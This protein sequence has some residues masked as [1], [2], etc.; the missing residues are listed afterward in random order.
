MKS[1]LSLLAFVFFLFSVALQGQTNFISNGNKTAFSK[2][3]Q[4]SVF[5]KTQVFEPVKSISADSENVLKSFSKDLNAELSNQKWIA[6]LKENKI[7]ESRMKAQ[8][9]ITFIKNTNQDKV[10]LFGNPLMGFT[11][12]KLV[13]DEP[14][15]F[16]NTLLVYS[17]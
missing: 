4:F 5:Q 7:G 12:K 17:F 13:F 14:A 6:I 16:S 1:I 9:T 2:Q 8:D 11:E 15:L 3:I 10:N